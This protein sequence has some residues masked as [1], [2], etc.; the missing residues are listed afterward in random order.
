MC[1]FGEIQSLSRK[2]VMS[3]ISTYLSMQINNNIKWQV[4]VDMEKHQTQECWKV[5][6][7][8]QQS[9]LCRFEVHFVSVSTGGMHL[10]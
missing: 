4:R 3:R 6:P 7:V 2:I 10:V 1:L 5:D 8:S 9:M